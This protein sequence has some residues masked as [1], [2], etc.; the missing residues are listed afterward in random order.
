MAFL[1][2]LRQAGCLIRQLRSS[3]PADRQPAWLF[4]LRMMHGRAW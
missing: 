1:P 4:R 2:G 3:S